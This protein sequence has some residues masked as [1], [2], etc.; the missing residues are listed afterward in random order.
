MVVWIPAFAGMSGGIEMA[1]WVYML[2]NRKGGTLYI[3]MTEKLAKRIWSHK[4]KLTKGFAARYNVDKLVWYEP[5]ET[6][7]S[8]FQRER[9]MK[10]WNRAW[11]IKRIEKENPD[12]NDLHETLM[13]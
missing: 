9:A 4:E 6:R 2:A 5:H 13:H 7:E 11:K 1:F 3:G 10:K 8:A 12:W